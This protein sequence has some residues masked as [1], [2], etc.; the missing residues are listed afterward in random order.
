MENVQKIIEKIKLLKLI[1]SKV[2][3]IKERKS[4]KTEDK[5][6]FELESKLNNL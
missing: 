4:N 2:R 3:E 5:T 1:F 6:I